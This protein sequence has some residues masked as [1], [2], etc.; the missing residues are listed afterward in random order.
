MGTMKDPRTDY[1]DMVAEIARRDGVSLD[2]AR[3][4]LQCESPRLGRTVA[5]FEALAA[6]K[7][8]EQAKREADKVTPNSK[9]IMDNL[10]AT[11]RQRS[12]AEGV[13]LTEAA[14][15]LHRE[16]PDLKANNHER[17]RTEKKSDESKKENA[18]TVLMGIA[19]KFQAE[20]PGLAFSAA[21]QRAM[22]E[23]PLLAQQV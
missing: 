8:I 18:I 3:F 13:T 6:G 12:E 20:E 16:H 9:G 1:E 2:S 21:Y 22:D 5:Y 4:K 7:T 19:R 17:F 15:K 11:I 10:T 23:N 14:R